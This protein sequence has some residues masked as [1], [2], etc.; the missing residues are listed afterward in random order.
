MRNTSKRVPRQVPGRLVGSSMHTGGKLWQHDVRFE[1]VTVAPCFVC[2]R[3]GRAKWPQQG[4]VAPVF[5][6]QKSRI[7]CMYKC[8]NS[9]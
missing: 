9:A 2:F 7:L 5:F 4:R 3:G 1:K 6:T 8:D